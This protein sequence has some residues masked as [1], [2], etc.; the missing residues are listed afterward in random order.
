MEQELSQ[1]HALLDAAE[2][3]WPPVM[4]TYLKRPKNQ[5]L[6]DLPPAVERVI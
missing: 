5:E 3:D 1:Q 2:L 6:H 4:T